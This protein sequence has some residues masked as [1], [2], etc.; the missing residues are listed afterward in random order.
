MTSVHFFGSCIIIFFVHTKCALSLNTSYVFA[1]SSCHV[2]NGINYDGHDIANFAASHASDCCDLC[3]NYFGCTSWTFY[4]ST[5]YLKSSTRERS[6]ASNCISGTVSADRCV[7]DDKISYDGNDLSSSTVSSDPG[8][9]ADECCSLCGMTFGCTAWTWYE[10]VCYIKNSTAGRVSC[11]NCVSG[12]PS[13]HLPYPLP[14]KFSHAGYTFTGGRY[15]PNVTMGSS[16]SHQSMHHLRTT[17]TDWIAIVVTQYQYNIDSTEI[18]P[19]YDPNKILDTECHYYTF[20]TLTEDE[21]KSAIRYAHSLGFK[22]MLKPHI[23]LIEN[24]NPCGKYWRGDIGTNFN[25]T[26]WNTW[27]D[28][29]SNFFLPYATM[30]QKEKVEMLSM[31]CELVVPNKQEQHW[32]QLIKRTRDVYQHGLITESAISGHEQEVTWW[33][34]VDIIGSDFYYDIP[35]DNVAEMVFSLQSLI[36][37]MKELSTKFNRNVTFTEIGYC[38]GHCSRTHKPNVNDFEKHAMH[39]QAIL[40]AMSPT[41]KKNQWFMGA[42]WW[43]WNTDDGYTANDDCLTAQW[44]PAE[45]VLRYYYQATKPKPS[46]LSASRGC[47]GYRQCTC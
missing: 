7:I 29:Y 34:A 24:K 1:N 20:V 42:F 11:S 27:F 32:R 33:D 14:N 39:Y 16:Y 6:N 9:G 8:R 5:C 17:G 28:S 2:E 35:G 45:D 3:T 31:N 19:L 13:K 23:D 30:A 25:K 41:Q 15:C 46:P 47:T 40:A 43:N 36:K 4:Q 22:V 38:S 26:Q 10:S 18:F 12:T 37:D 21:V 44:K